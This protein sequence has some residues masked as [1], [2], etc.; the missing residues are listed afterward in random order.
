MHSNEDTTDWSNPQALLE[1]SFIDP[2]YSKKGNPH[3]D[4]WDDASKG[5]KRNEKENQTKSQSR[6]SLNINQDIELQH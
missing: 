6:K 3:V 2:F 1:D 5:S 4:V